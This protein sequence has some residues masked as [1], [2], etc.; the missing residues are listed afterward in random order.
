MSLY[1]CSPAWIRTR[2]RRLEI[3]GDIP[4][5]TEPFPPM[6]YF[7]VDIARFI[8]SK[9]KTVLP[10]Q[11]S[12]AFG[13]L[14]YLPLFPGDGFKDVRL[15]TQYLLKSCIKDFCTSLSHCCQDRIRTCSSIIF[16]KVFSIQYLHLE[17]EILDK[18]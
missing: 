14:C 3:F 15:I 2:N 12:Q 13:R 10:I 6:R 7:G 5:T 1:F 17:Y 18:L 9:T 16:Y 11:K 4:F 8:L